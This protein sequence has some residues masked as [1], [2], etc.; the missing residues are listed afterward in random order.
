[1]NSKCI[2]YIKTLKP[3]TVGV[4]LI[5]INGQ[6]LRHKATTTF[7]I[8]SD[9]YMQ[10]F[11]NLCEEILELEIDSGSIFGV[12]L[13]KDDKYKRKIV[14]S[15]QLIF[16]IVTKLGGDN[17]K[18]GDFYKDYIKALN[19]TERTAISHLQEAIKTGFI[20]QISNNYIKLGVSPNQ[21]KEALNKLKTSQEEE[22]KE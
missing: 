21:E 2:A 3:K 22:V 17:V 4:V 1:M 6:S 10:I 14:D 9:S 20:A 8:D 5:A 19:C 16:E 7:N 11:N 18:K 12:S 13:P 15:N